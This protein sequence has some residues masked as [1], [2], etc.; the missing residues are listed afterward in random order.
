MGVFDLSGVLNVQKNYISDLSGISQ[1]GGNIN[2]YTT[3][4]TTSLG[5]ISTSYTQAAAVATDVLTKQ[6]T[7][8]T[9]LSGETERLNAK[10]QQID[11][12]L[13]TQNRMIK[14]NDSYRKRTAQYTYGTMIIIFALLI[15][16]VLVKLPGWLPVPE[17]IINLLTVIL[18]AFTIITMWK[19]NSSIQQRDLIDYDQIKL[20]GPKIPTEDEITKQKQESQAAGDISAIAND[21]SCV[22]ADCCDGNASTWNAGLNKCVMKCTGNTPFDD[23]GKCVDKCPAD[24]KEC[25]SSCIANNATCYEFESFS[26]L[27]ANSAYEYNSYAPYK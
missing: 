1:N 12:A 19:L 2:P 4:L 20:P 13:Q 8:N 23:N 3:N 15:Y 25:G 6:N 11:N 9:I 18:I 5:N 26:G 10:K 14:L 24:K 21:G 22:G 16:I 7:V 27:E 17:G